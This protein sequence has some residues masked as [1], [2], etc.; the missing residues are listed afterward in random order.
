VCAFVG[1]VE[2]HQDAELRWGPQP[3]EIHRNLGTH[4]ARSSKSVVLC[5]RDLHLHVS[6]SNSYSD[7]SGK[8]FCWQARAHACLK[9]AAHFVLFIKRSCHAILGTTIA[10]ERVIVR[11]VSFT[12]TSPPQFSWLHRCEGC[13][14]WRPYFVRGKLASY[15]AI[16]PHSLRTIRA[17]Q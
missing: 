16:K 7:P 10:G 12:S 1:V 15:P 5:F 3:G 4:K 2:R 11:R 8:R 14:T 9:P 6:L 13:C 17:L